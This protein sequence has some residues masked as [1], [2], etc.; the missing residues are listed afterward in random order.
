MIRDPLTGE[1]ALRGATRTARPNEFRD[2]VSQPCPFCPG[3][4]HLTP[5]ERARIGT[6]DAWSARA[7]SNL[8]PAIQ[9]PE[10]DH[11]VIVDSAGHDEEITLDGTRLWRERYASA[12]Q[13]TPSSFPVL[14]KNRGA[15]AGATI[16][17][18]HAQLIVLPSRPPRWNAMRGDCILC[19]ERSHAPERG[20]LVATNGASDAFVR[21]CSR[22]ARALT[23]LPKRCAP[24]MLS[25]DAGWEA[26]IAQ[27]RSSTEGLMRSYGAAAAFN[28]LVLADPQDAFH[29]HLELIPRLETLAGFELATGIFIRGGSAQES[30]AAWRR[31][32]APPDG[33]V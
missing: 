33:P 17:H 29:W 2:N 7:F 31:M 9:P 14:F 15:Y 10:G 3:N 26:A 24:T 1:Y 30:A 25:E 13:N 28:V 12:L 27:L 8:F 11:E 23:I 5:P 21:E 6:S 20:T 19:E 18:P 4:E 16:S 22:F 32:V